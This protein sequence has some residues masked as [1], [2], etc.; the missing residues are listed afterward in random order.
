MKLH[1]RSKRRKREQTRA[2]LELY[3]MRLVVVKNPQ[4][5]PLP[6]GPLREV[7]PRSLSVSTSTID[8]STSSNLIATILASDGR[9]LN[10]GNV[11]TLGWEGGNMVTPCA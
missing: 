4:A 8:L 9:P 1:P 11:D 6:S 7:L 10:N 3:R 5:S 2:K